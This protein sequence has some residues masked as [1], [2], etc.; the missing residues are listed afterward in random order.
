[1]TAQVIDATVLID[2]LRGH[3]PATA[4]LL[5]LPSPPVCSEITRV[6]VDRGLRSGE[7]GT[8]RRLF[9]AIDWIAVDSQIATEAA[10]FGRRYRRSHHTIDVADLIVA[11]TAL[12]L[13]SQPSTTNIKHF[14][15]FPGLAPPY[16]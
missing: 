9:A 11:A 12:S 2:H 15:M 6:E 5:N 10:E 1:M 8:A 13:G 3:E 7:R 4:Y 14:P 16:V